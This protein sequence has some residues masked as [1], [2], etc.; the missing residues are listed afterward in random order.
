M[1][2]LINPVVE[3]IQIGRS[4]FMI[5]LFKF[6]NPLVKNILNL[7]GWNFK[8]AFQIALFEVFCQ[9][10][11]DIEFKEAKPFVPLK[12]KIPGM[13]ILMK[14]NSKMKWVIKVKAVMKDFY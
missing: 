13:I 11:N 1:I 10:V 14:Q 3:P 12:L 6:K 9:I 4:N 7:I 5:R 2:N 8:M